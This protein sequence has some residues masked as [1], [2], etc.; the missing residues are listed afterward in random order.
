ML[1]AI[2]IPALDSS[3]EK[4]TLL[5]VL[6]TPGQQ[7]QKGATVAEIETEKATFPVDS[8]F[9]GRVEKLL[10][11]AGTE[12]PV[13][14]ALVTIETDDAG[15][16]PFMEGEAPVPTERTAA[17]SG[18]Y[19][20]TQPKNVLFNSSA[21]S[22]AINVPAPMRY[23]GSVEE[24][25][26]KFAARNVPLAESR[27]LAGS[28]LRTQQRM[29][30]SAR[31]VPASSVSVPL[32]VSTLRDRVQAHRGATKQ[33]LNPTD[34]VIW[35][36][37]RALKDFPELNAYRDGEELRFYARINVGI[38]YDVR[39]ELNLPAVLNA[40]ALSLEAF[41]AE[42]RTL[43]KELTAKSLPLEKLGVATFVVSN[44]F[45]SGAT[46]AHPLV[47]AGNSAV[48][49]IGAPYQQA[50][51]DESGMRFA[52]HTNLVLGFDHSIVNG[53]RASAYLRAVVKLIDAA[54]FKGA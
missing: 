8:P 23:G 3:T 1:T 24:S 49:L 25:A 39:G 5:R 48:L 12:L 50:R 20:C 29:T 11:A 15:A 33:L 27:K 18:L 6:V 44:L 41:S 38:V 53:V 54:E 43:Y 17:S 34:V 16:E 4:A 35:A 7:I 10:A 19:A 37:A 52:E 47:N 51:S 30:Y 21:A 2:R 32:E 9:P 22:P 13:S 42:L 46:Q 28:A 40:D 36:A 14:A 26:E 45:G 31:Q